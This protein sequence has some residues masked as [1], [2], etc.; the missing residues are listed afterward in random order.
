MDERTESKTRLLDEV[1]ARAAGADGDDAEAMPEFV[2]QYF[3]LVA[4]DDLLDRD[5]ESLL[6]TACSHWQLLADR[7]PGTARVRVFNPAPDTDGW[8]SAHTV[9]QVVTDD[10]PFVVDSLSVELSRVG[11]GIHL[12]IHPTVA[13]RRTL[14]GRLVEL[15]ATDAVADDAVVE[16][17]VHVEIDRDPGLDRLEELRRSLA[18]VLEDVRAAVEDWP[19][20]QA[21]MLYLVDELGAEPPDVLDDVDET[22]EFLRWIADGHFTFL[23]YRDYDLVDEGG[24]DVLRPILGSGLGVLRDSGYQPQSISF[25]KLPA[26]VRRRARERTLLSLTKANSPLDRAPAGL[27]GLHRRQAV[28]RGRRAGRGTALPWAVHAHGLRGEPPRR[29]AGPPQGAGGARPGRPAAD[30]PSRQGA[31]RGDGEL[32][33]DELFQASV[34]QLYETA[35]GVVHIQERQRVRLFVRPD[36]F[37]RFVSCLVYLPRDRYTTAVR[38]RMQAL[39]TEAYGGS[40]S[41]SSRRCPSRCSCGSTSW[42][43][44][45]RATCSRRTW[46]TWRRR[47]PTR[48]GRGMTRCVRRSAPSSVRAPGSSWPSATSTRSRRRTPRTSPPRPRSPTCRSSSGSPRRGTSPCTS[49]SRPTRAPAPSGSRSS[50]TGDPIAVSDV[51]P[52]L[53]NLGVRVLDE[54]PYGIRVG[55]GAPRAWIYDF[56]LA[57]AGSVRVDVDELRDRF[58]RAFAMVWSG[59]AES[60]G[61]NRLVLRAGIDWR[62]VTVLRAYA[63]YL[64]QTRSTYSTA[65][66]DDAIVNNPDIAA[67][68]VQLFHSRLD[69]ELAGDARE[70][71]R[72]AEAVESA[73]AGVMSL[74]EDRILRAMLQLVWSRCAPTTSSRAPTAGRRA[75]CPSSSTPP[76]CPTCRCR[77]RCTRCSSTRRG[78]RACTCAAGRS[79]A[80]GSGGPTGARTSA[81]RCSA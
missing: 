6:G 66:I 46:R 51:L 15:L 44:S 75:T 76:R 8:Q 53:Q 43:T 64:R 80:A 54:R 37:G 72:L 81:P 13:V 38:E 50:G 23:G 52:L 71:G 62:D 16:S 20:M 24:E 3:A 30:E 49:T 1:A 4:P 12:M 79:R 65:Y 27:P 58:E 70:A 36:A 18:S 9:V 57:A 45:T 11:R 41:T 34:D 39:L 19:K 56:G 78:W 59:A 68:L 67:L 40:R 35:M 32:S 74:D 28:R 73:L 14:D 77:G 63:R 47:S 22:R 26:D 25:A 10:M 7:P 31:R 29:A 48:P 5:A 69:P 33:P 42:C 61:L 2:R 60:D 55:G 21:R 17:L